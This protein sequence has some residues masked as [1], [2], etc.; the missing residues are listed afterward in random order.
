MYKYNPTVFTPPAASPCTAARGIGTKT[1]Q[2]SQ[3]GGC[4]A[5]AILQGDLTQW[6]ELG[7][8]HVRESIRSSSG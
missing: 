6:E 8:W 2:V 1:S 5:M 7:G 3:G 4:R